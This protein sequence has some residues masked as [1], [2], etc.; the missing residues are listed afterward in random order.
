[1]SVNRNSKSK[2]ARVLHNID[3]SITDILTGV[4]YRVFATNGVGLMNLA[5]IQ[6][7]TANHTWHTVSYKTA[8][9]VVATGHRNP[10]KYSV[11]MEQ[12]RVIPVKVGVQV[13]AYRLCPDDEHACTGMPLDGNR[14]FGQCVVS[15]DIW[16]SKLKGSFYR[17]EH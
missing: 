7:H 17:N 12:V 1:M 4:V 11:E 3:E 2:V 13:R 9:W 16:I 10:A 15:D 5:E 6:C 8:T 14:E